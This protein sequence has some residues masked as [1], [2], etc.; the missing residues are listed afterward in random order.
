[1]NGDV[2][3]HVLCERCW[4]PISRSEPRARLGHIVGSTLAGDVRWAYTYLHVYD[5]ETGCVRQ[6][7]STQS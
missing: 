6:E 2:P 4:N 7:T 1:M 5:P 3:V